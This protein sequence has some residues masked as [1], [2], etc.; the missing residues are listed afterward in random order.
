MVK[1]WPH[2]D[3]VMFLPPA[4]LESQGE[5]EPSKMASEALIFIPP[6]L[7]V[8]IDPSLAESQRQNK[9]VQQ[10]QCVL[11]HSVFSMAASTTVF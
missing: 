3:G 6:V 4:S 1:V 2:L 5:L 8:C 9:F 11:V 7:R 10:L